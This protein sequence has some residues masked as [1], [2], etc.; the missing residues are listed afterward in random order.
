MASHQKTVRVAASRDYLEAVVYVMLSG[1]AFE[2]F[3]IQKLVEGVWLPPRAAI[4][5]FGVLFD[6]VRT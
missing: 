6:V 4:R 2:S 1:A 5:A 3:G